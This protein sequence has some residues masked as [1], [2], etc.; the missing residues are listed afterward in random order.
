MSTPSTPSWLAVAALAWSIVG[1]P[2]LAYAATRPASGRL[3][4]HAALMI[5][6]VVLEV[7]G[8]FVFDLVVPPSPRRAALVDL[9][10]FKIHLAFAIASLLGMAWQLG[11]R[12]RPAARRMHR[13]TG[14]Y[15]V[16]IW[17]LA[18]LTGI[19]NYV[20]LYVL[21]RPS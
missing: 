18:L 2:Y 21:R 19:Y 9:P 5:A 3:R 8:L 17:S 14:P 6:A 7:G 12:T 4:L 16:L 10:F 15:V 1:V 11:T 20:F 13:A